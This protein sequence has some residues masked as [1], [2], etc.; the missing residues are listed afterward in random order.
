[1]GTAKVA[2]EPYSQDEGF[3][4]LL[5]TISH[6]SSGDA[7][8]PTELARSM[9]LDGLPNRE[10]AKATLEK[11]VLAPVQ[12]LS[13]GEL[14]RWQTYVSS[15][16]SVDRADDDSQAPIE[17]PLPRLTLSPLPPTHQILPTTRGINGA[18]THWRSALAPRPPAHPALS[19]STNRAFGDSKNFVRGKGSY[20]PFLPGGLEPETVVAEEEDED[21]EDEEEGWKTRAPGLRR[22]VKL[23]GA[24]EFLAEMLGQQGLGGKAKRRRMDGGGDEGA[25]MEVQKL[26][27]EAEGEKKLNGFGGVRK[28]DDLLPIGV[29]TSW[30]LS[31]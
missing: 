2:G 25:G 16:W 23:D 21:G 30:D 18:F 27:Y 14:W 26:G 8:S 3:R 22:G 10:E 4:K 5:Q 24:D 13:G 15:L 9:G 20:A 17:L 6:P 19:S 28:V 11:E 12:D 7:L 29:S 31:L 1:M